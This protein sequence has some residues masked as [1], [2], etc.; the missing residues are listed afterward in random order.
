MAHDASISC[1]L[2]AWMRYNSKRRP[3]VYLNFA[4]NVMGVSKEL[5]EEAAIREGI[6]AF[7]AFIKRAGVPASLADLNI[8]PE[9]FDSIIDG[10]RG[11]SFNSDGVLSCNPVMT[12]ADIKNVLTNSYERK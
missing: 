3:G 11:V 2:P 4:R 10:V 9:H 1:L 7:E 12:A 6:D 8:S 5:P